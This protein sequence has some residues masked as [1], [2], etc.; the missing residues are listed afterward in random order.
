MA[1]LTDPDSLS[2]HV[3]G[4]TTSTTQEVVINTST[5]TI[6]LRILGNLNDDSPGKE[7]GVTAKA[8]YS[9]LK[10]EWLNGAGG[11]SAALR[12]FKFPLKMIFEG[13]FIFVNG[14]APADDQT[15]DLIRDAGF[16]EALSGDE[17]A[18]F[19]SLGSMDNPA[20][21]LAYYTQAAGFT[22]VPTDF[23]KTGELNENVQIYEST[24]PINSRGYFKAF[25]REQGKLYS[26]YNLLT[27]QGISTL[28]YQAYSFPLSNATD[29]K[30]S[31]SDATISTTSPYNGMKINYLKGTGFTTMAATTYV[32]GNVVKDS[33]NRW[34]FCTVGGTA[35]GTSVATGSGT[36]TF[37]PYEGERQ[38]G[39][40]WYA[41]N[42][43]IAGN[44]GTAQQIY[45][46]MQWSLRQTGNIN[47]NDPTLGDGSI[48]AAQLGFGTVNGNV[49]LPLGS[50]VGDNLKP[51]GGVWLDNFNVNSTNNIQHSPIDL[52]AGG[53]TSESIPVSSTEVAFPFVSAGS[54]NFSSNLVAQPDAQTYYTV[55][56]D[57]IRRT[58]T[59]VTITPTTGSTAT[60]AYSAGAL[61]YLSFTAGGVSGTTA[62][63]FFVTGATNAINNGL[64][65]MASNPAANAFTATKVAGGTPVSETSST[66]TIDENPFE[67]PE[68]FIVNNNA[69]S[70]LSGQITAASIPFDFDYTNNAQGGRIP[71]STAACRIVAQALSG[72]EWTETAFNITNATGITVTITANDERNYS[73]P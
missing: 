48:S 27:E 55:Y 1:K 64:W 32:V 3:V 24:G 25:L 36:C 60:F 29:L 40:T 13:S 51:S 28:N 22:Q 58:T 65:R 52:N 33:T 44:G 63:Y 45:E 17:Y 61:N 9:F 5:K 72:A 73:N 68:A 11:I 21:D 62:D 15:R 10:E 71:A 57:Y 16:Q 59:T 66:L 14:W 35:T 18:C 34:F 46:W 19:V 38:I 67:S 26:E 43:I 69:G 31:A 47:A 12:R 8:L 70:P 2:L 6:Q 42:R 37:Q 56:F 23:D 41:F 53:L 4:V 20:V 39:T 7:S 49:A 30:I 54:F 50:F